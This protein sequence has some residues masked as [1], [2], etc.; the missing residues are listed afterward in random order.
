MRKPMRNKDILPTGMW[1]NNFFYHIPVG[2]NEKFRL[3]D[4][5]EWNIE[6]M[7]TVLQNLQYRPG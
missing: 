4:L 6:K 1:E 5:Q 2:R 7:E 3:H